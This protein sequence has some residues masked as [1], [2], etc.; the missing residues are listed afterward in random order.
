MVRCFKQS[1]AVHCQC[2]AKLSKPSN[3][4]NSPL[5]EDDNT[6]LESGATSPQL[7]VDS[8]AINEWCIIHKEKTYTPVFEDVGCRLRIQV[9]ALSQADNSILAGPIDLFTEPVL[10]APV[11]PHKKRLTALSGAAAG[12]APT[13]PRFRVVSYN[14]LAEIYAT[15]QVRHKPDCDY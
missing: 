2:H 8:S 9:T 6:P 15:K 13:A 11:A 12:V 14:I 1:W 10:S 3:P 5:A 7:P 4:S